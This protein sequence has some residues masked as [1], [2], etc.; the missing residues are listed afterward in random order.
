MTPFD[1]SNSGTGNCK[2]V[3][4]AGSLEIHV[5]QI[6]GAGTLGVGCSAVIDYVGVGIPA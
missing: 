2:L 6:P 1:F 4:N 5:Q 3:A